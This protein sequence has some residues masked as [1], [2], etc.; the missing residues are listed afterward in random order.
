MVD[1]VQK[2][3]NTYG[4]E[5]GSTAAGYNL[6]G[7][8]YISVGATPAGTSGQYLCEMLFSPRGILPKKADNT[9]G[10]SS[11]YYCD[12]FWFNNSGTRVP[13]R[14]GHSNYGAWVGAFFADLTD[15]ASGARWTQGAGLSCKPLA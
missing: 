7:N 4:T 1:G 15:V 2:V 11:K 10:A 14:G 6:T 8:G 9:V 5:D 3:K 12:G 13:I